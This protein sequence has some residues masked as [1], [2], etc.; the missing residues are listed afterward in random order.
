MTVNCL[1]SAG[2]SLPFGDFHCFLSAS[3]GL[4]HSDLTKSIREVQSMPVHLPQNTN[5]GRQTRHD[6]IANNYRRKA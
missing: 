3:S 6:D 4:S 1:L 5:P 2:R